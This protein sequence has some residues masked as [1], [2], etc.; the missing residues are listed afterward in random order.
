MNLESVFIQVE[1]YI[2]EARRMNREYVLD[3]YKEYNSVEGESFAYLCTVKDSFALKMADKMFSTVDANN[4]ELERISEWILEGFKDS[5]Y[6]KKNKK[7]KQNLYFRQSLF[8]WR[9]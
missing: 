2:K 5:T 4:E 3:D 1:K 8:Y 6:I 9:V 7:R